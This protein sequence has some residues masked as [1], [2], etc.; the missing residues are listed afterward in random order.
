MLRGM[1]SSKYKPHRGRLKLIFQNI[2]LIFFLSYPRICLVIVKE[3]HKMV[4]RVAF[5][6]L[7]SVKYWTIIYVMSFNLATA[8]EEAKQIHG[9]DFYNSAFIPPV[10]WIRFQSRFNIYF[11]N[12]K[13]ARGKMKVSQFDCPLQSKCSITAMKWILLT[14]LTF[15]PGTIKGSQMIVLLINT[16]SASNAVFTLGV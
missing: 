9:G 1:Q 6:K 5:V 14:L 13:R 4:W 16:S 15:V 12:I 2:F 8:R 11:I 7:S 3:I 10:E